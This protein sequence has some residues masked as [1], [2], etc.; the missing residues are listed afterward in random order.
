MSKITKAAKHI[1]SD[2]RLFSQLVI[3]MKLHAYQERP[4]LAIVDS[5]LHQRGHEFLLVFSRQSGKNEAIAH[6]QTY[7]LNLLQRKG[8]NIVFGAIADGIGRGIDRL[9]QRLDNQWNA[10]HW[11]KKSKPV[12]RT[13]GK[14]AV[15]FLS[16][17]P[18]AASRGETAE[19]FLFHLN[20]LA[21]F[22][23]KILFVLVLF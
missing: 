22:C 2:I 13:L 12:R 15:A 3:G 16:T 6:L 5:V 19:P 9:E 21:S 14:A 20:L 4:L 8:G 7:L 1:L 11:G 17:H 18:S 10:P 23:Q